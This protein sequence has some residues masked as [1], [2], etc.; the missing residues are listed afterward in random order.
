MTIWSL[1]A[2]SPRDLLFPVPQLLY[3]CDILTSP[4]D[5]FSDRKLSYSGFTAETL[6]WHPRTIWKD[7]ELVFTPS[8]TAATSQLSYFHTSIPACSTSGAFLK[9]SKIIFF[10]PS[11]TFGNGSLGFLACHFSES[12]ATVQIWAHR[13]QPC[14][15][16]VSQRPHGASPAS[17]QPASCLDP[18]CGPACGPT[19]GGKSPA[20]AHAHV[21][22][23]VQGPWLSFTGKGC[24]ISYNHGTI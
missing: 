16:E 2:N 15:Q 14:S 24:V 17:I 5:C 4:P 18:A 10:P 12:C 11:L 3:T 6:L 20:D 21:L 1:V 7:I 23:G 22:C 8:S 9:P 19:C 13:A